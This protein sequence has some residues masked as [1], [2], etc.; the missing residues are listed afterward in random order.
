V[1]EKST[2]TDLN[3]KGIF[4]VVVPSNEKNV[5]SSSSDMSSACINR[6]Q[7]GSF[8]PPLDWAGEGFS[9][10]WARTGRCASLGRC[11][12]RTGKEEGTE[13]L[14]DSLLSSPSQGTKEGPADS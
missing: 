3:T 5:G 14:T 8:L 11:V 6:G 2:Q 12:S 4:V 13:V 7:T 9:E 10:F 1:I